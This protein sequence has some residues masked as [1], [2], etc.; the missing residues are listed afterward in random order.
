MNVDFENIY[1]ITVNDKWWTLFDL[2]GLRLKLT[3]PLTVEFYPNYVGDRNFITVVNYLVVHSTKH[4][5]RFSDWVTFKGD[6]PF[7]SHYCIGLHL[8]DYDYFKSAFK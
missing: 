2:R 1:D 5:T 8:L 6:G 4:N 3:T 7:D